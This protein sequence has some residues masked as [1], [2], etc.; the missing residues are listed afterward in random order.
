[1]HH[2][3]VRRDNDRM[4]EPTLCHSFISLLI[5]FVICAP[6]TEYTHYFATIF[7]IEG[8]KLSTNIWYLLLIVQQGYS[9]KMKYNIKNALFSCVH[10]PYIW[11]F[12]CKHITS[13]IAYLLLFDSLI[14]FFIFEGRKH[15]FVFFLFI[16]IC[17]VKSFPRPSSMSSSDYEYFQ[18]QNCS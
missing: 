4:N 5:S 18:C 8:F 1:M 17:R 15:Y 9:N 7:L 10:T 6:W 12:C 11:Y 2:F 16:R 13:L 14:F 3:Y